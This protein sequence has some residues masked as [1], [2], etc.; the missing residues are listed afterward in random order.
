[1]AEIFNRC[2]VGVA[3]ITVL[4]GLPVAPKL[5]KSLLTLEAVAIM[6]VATRVSGCKLYELYKLER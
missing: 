4:H 5:R 2:V 6:R 1:M 3:G